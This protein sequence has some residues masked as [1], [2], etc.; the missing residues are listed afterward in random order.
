MKALIIEDVRKC[1]VQEVADPTLTDDGVIVKIKANGICRSDWHIWSGDIPITQSIIGHEF[2]GVVEEVGSSIRNFKKG[3][4]VA[5]PFTGSDGTCPMCQQGHS[6]LCDHRTS[7]GNTFQGGYAEYTMVPNADRNLIHLPE[8]ISFTEGAA[9]GCRLM[10]AFHGVTNRG[11]VKPGEWVVV[12]G[13]GGVGLSAINIASSIG[14]LVIGVD[15]NDNN[16]RLAKEMGAHYTINSKEQN[17]VKAIME[18][19]KGGAHVSI[20]ALGIDETTVNSVLSLRK[21]GRHVQ[22]GVTTKEEGGHVKLPVDLI[23]G[24]EL[25]FFGSFGMPSHQIPSIFPLIIGGK[26]SPGKMVTGEVALKDVNDV[27]ENMSN[28][29]NNGTFVVTKF[30]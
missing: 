19:T 4:R 26:I 29:T 12:Y 28:F 20:D 6:N 9:I 5:V 18:L 25:A 21:R 27:F 17:P 11:Q 7:P 16:L 22:I 8:E 1:S 2:T 23:V 30:E 13:C 15:I 10:T 24:K 3:D 14:A